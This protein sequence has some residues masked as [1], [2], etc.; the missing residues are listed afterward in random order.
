MPLT[1]DLPI[2]RQRLGNKGVF[3]AGVDVL[4]DGGLAVINTSGYAV[5]GQDAA[6]YRFGGVVD[7]QVDNSGGP[8]GAK[9]VNLHREGEFL[10]AFSGTATQA[11]VGKRV[12][13]VDDQTV[14]LAQ[15]GTGNVFAGVITEYVSASQVWV[16]IEPAAKRMPGQIEVLS[17]DL[18]AVTGTTVGG[19]LQLANPFGQTVYILDVLLDVTTEATGAAT[20]DVGVAADASTGSDTL[21]DG[22]DVGSAAI[23]ANNIDNK[24]TNGRRS[25]KWTASQYIN[26]TASATLAGLVGTY[27]ITVLIPT[28]Q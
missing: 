12:Y 11:D 23:L 15:P 7:G 5:A 16:D 24:G 4:Y 20:A 25:R 9:K 28:A 21:L 27:Y 19:M 18:T 1:R 10:L 26:G 13:V 6:G 3:L 2:Q 22:V 14:G 17:G 8:A